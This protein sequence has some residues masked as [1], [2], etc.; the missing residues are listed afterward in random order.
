MSRRVPRTL[1][2]LKLDYREIAALLLFPPALPL[3]PVSSSSTFS[4]SVRSLTAPP[5][6]RPPPPHPPS[7]TSSS[8]TESRSQSPPCRSH[9]PA[10]LRTTKPT[11]CRWPR[12]TPEV[13]IRVRDV[14][15]ARVRACACTCACESRR[16]DT[17][18]ACETCVSVSP[19]QLT[20]RR[21]GAG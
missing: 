17:I 11:T 20:A 14:P 9:R 4:S 3:Y 6:L 2:T 5:L 15:P 19:T 18:R 7:R 13:G 1:R 21:D 8:T 16:C 10:P 12:S